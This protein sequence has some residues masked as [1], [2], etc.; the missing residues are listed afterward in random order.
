MKDMG[1][2]RTT[3]STVTR[4]Q[5]QAENLTEI[6]EIEKK[7]VEDFSSEMDR[8]Y[9]LISEKTSDLISITTFSPT[10]TYVYVSPSHK[11][12]LGYDSKDLLGKCPFDMIHPED[13]ERIRKPQR[14]A[15][16][17]QFWKRDIRKASLPIKGQTGELALP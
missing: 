1:T 10:P 8:R 2:F 4:S 3:V 12:L 6:P 9:R 17:A 15:K 11:S 14:P 16:L 13:V 5:E 7:M